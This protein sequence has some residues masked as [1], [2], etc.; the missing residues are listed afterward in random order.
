V[1][2]F[3]T[4]DLVA[5]QLYQSAALYVTINESK[6]HGYKGG[7]DCCGRNNTGDGFRTTYAINTYH[8]TVLSSNPSHAK[9]TRY[10]SI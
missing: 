2:R 1:D 9:C 10:Y 5:T 3:K 7:G 4:D 6:T 8:Y